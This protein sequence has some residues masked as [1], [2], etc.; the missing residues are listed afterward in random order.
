MDMKMILQRY[1]VTLSVLASLALLT[2]VWAFHIFHRA[3]RVG[4][5]WLLL[6]AS[7]P[8]GLPASLRLLLASLTIAV[9]CHAL[10]AAGESVDRVTN[11]MTDA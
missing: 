7:S 11:P 1:F 2:S 3:S 4:V 5:H 10:R 8:S 9:A 6:S